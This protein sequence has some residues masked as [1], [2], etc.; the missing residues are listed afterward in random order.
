[1]GAYL[2]IAD[3]VV[4][5]ARVRLLDARRFGNYS[6][7][8]RFS[9]FSAAARRTARSWQP[10]NGK[11]PYCKTWMTANGLLF[12]NLGENR[13]VSPASRPRT[14]DGETPCKTPF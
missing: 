5:P 6:T 2:H 11:P 13:C 4:P 12:P 3:W 8:L 14:S 9:T 1:M 7:N 10:H